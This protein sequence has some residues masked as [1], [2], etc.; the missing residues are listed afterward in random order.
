MVIFGSVAPTG[1]V[2]SKCSC[3]G[4]DP[5][6]A[7]GCL[8]PGQEASVC[9]LLGG[10]IHAD[11]CAWQAGTGIFPALQLPASF[12][13]EPVPGGVEH[14]V[15]LGHIDEIRPPVYANRRNHG[16]RLSIDHADVVRAA[17]DD[18]DFIL[19]LVR[20]NPRGIAADRN[21]FG[22]CERPKVNDADRIA[23]SVADVGVLAV[24]GPVVRQRLLAEIPP[25]HSAKNGN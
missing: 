3:D 24:G 2:I 9:E 23:F 15:I 12:E 25:A 4:P 6:L 11:V 17:V 14:S 21:G 20:R 13:N 7:D 19:L 5:G 18:I 22:E 16:I 1:S 10:E 8:Q